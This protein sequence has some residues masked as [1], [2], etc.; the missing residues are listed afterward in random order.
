M[1]HLNHLNPPLCPV[2]IWWRTMF[3][4]YL[5]TICILFTTQGNVWFSF[6]GWSHTL[7][8]T[9]HLRFALE[10]SWFTAFTKKWKVQLHQRKFR[11]DI[12]K[13]FFTERERTGSQQPQACQSSRSSLLV[14]RFNGFVLSKPARSREQD[15]GLMGPFH[16]K[17]FFDSV[18][19]RAQGSA[20]Q[21]R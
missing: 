4:P 8:A 17:I 15:L 9:P 5:L 6:L 21:H 2:P 14:T 10:L 19:M 13:S 20:H 1:C 11:S 7:Q 12:R 16:L 3:L 18:C